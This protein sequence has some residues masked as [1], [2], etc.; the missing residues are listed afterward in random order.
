MH[1]LY[2]IRQHPISYVSI[3]W[4]IC[5]AVLFMIVIVVVFVI[6]VMAGARVRSLSLLSRSN[7]LE[8]GSI[9]L[10]GSVRCCLLLCYCVS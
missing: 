4:F 10:A 2:T 8:V 9:M 3:I 5:L 7:L 6:V 1:S